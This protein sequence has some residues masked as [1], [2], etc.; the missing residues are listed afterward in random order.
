MPVF[1]ARLSLPQAQLF[2]F[3][4]LLTAR[5]GCCPAFA[6][7]KCQY[8]MLPSPLPYR[9]IFPTIYRSAPTFNRMTS[10]M[11]FIFPALLNQEEDL[12]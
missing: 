3:M 1:P 5:G 12:T 7:D 11:V 2:H 6:W 4:Q 10:A 8:W 9:S